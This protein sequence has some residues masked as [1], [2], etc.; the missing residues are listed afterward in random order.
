MKLAF[1]LPGRGDAVHEKRDRRV[2]NR[3]REIP[4][5]LA[6]QVGMHATARQADEQSVENPQPPLLERRGKEG[7]VPGGRIR[8]FLLLAGALLVRSETLRDLRECQP[9]VSPSGSGILRTSAA[10][11]ARTSSISDVKIGAGGIGELRMSASDSRSS[12]RALRSIQIV[13]RCPSARAGSGQRSTFLPAW[14]FAQ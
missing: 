11:C 5:V 10:A 2:A 3:D 14:S 7:I 9:W 13:S 4:A 8:R 1:G 6:G 12:P